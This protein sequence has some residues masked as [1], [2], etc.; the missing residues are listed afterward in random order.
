[1]RANEDFHVLRSPSTFAD[2]ILGA[3]MRKTA[4]IEKVKV[5]APVCK[6]RER[7]LLEITTPELLGSNARILMVLNR[8]SKF[9]EDLNNLSNKQQPH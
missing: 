5:L 1:M 2:R 6:N 3:V 7:E 8:L 9:G 4:I